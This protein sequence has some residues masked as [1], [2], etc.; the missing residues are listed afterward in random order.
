MKG[1]YREEVE[2]EYMERIA[3]LG[4][5]M[6]SFVLDKG[7]NEYDFI[8]CIELMKQYAWEKRGIRIT[9]SRA[10]D[11]SGKETVKGVEGFLKG[12]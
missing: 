7:Y 9:L 12:N 11:R 1:E 5:E 10:R 6:L 3:K 4:Q 2:A 8:T